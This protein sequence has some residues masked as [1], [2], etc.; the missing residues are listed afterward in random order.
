MRHR[1]SLRDRLYLSFLLT[2]EVTIVAVIVRYWWT[3]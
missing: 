1:L 2:V 3:A